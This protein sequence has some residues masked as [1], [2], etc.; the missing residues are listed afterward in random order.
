MRIYYSKRID[1]R[2]PKKRHVNPPK[3]ISDMLEIG[4]GITRVTTWGVTPNDGKEREW[5]SVG[6]ERQ[7]WDG[8]DRRAGIVNKKSI[9]A[10]E[11]Q[12]DIAL[13]KVV[14]GECNI[15]GDQGRSILRAIKRLEDGE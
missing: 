8:S 7:E 3:R 11:T 10:E 12:Q 1:G 2:G 13:L 15:S 6:D 14:W 9:D 5:Y 4:T